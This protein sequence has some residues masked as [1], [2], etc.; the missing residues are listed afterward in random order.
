MFTLSFP[1]FIL[2]DLRTKG[3]MYCYAINGKITN[4][5][6]VWK[7]TPVCFLKIQIDPYELK[8][9]NRIKMDQE[10]IAYFLLSTIFLQYF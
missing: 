4:R 2:E 10:N 9:E 6:D 8:L 3:E 5:T 7:G 1:K